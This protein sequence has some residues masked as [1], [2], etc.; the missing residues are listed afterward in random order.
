MLKIF[1]GY[2]LYLHFKCFPF[3][4]LLRKPPIPSSLPLPL[5]VCAPPTHPFPSSCPGIPLHWGIKHP[6]A[7]GLLLPLM[8]DKAILCHICGRSHGSLHVY[9]L[10]GGPV[11]RSFGE[12]GP[13]TLLLL[14]RG[15]KPLS[16]FSPF[17]NSCSRD[18][19]CLMCRWYCIHSSENI[20]RESN[21]CLRVMKP[22][23]VLAF[24]GHDVS[25]KQNKLK[26]HT[27][28]Q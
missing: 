11:P 8:S 25:R 19:F 13:L 10:V 16:S 28:T 2:F 4:G 20:C 9:S 3:S 14:P 17:S 12:S 27:V 26:S 7:Q 21:V 23:T 18:L 5:W 15:C 22:G 1:I 24:M 6:Q